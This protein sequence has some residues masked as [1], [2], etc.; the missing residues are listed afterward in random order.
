[1]APR[2]REREIGS[3]AHTRPWRK[4]VLWAR[5]VRSESTHFHGNRLHPRVWVSDRSASVSL[6]DLALVSG[7]D[8]DQRVQVAHAQ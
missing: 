7:F 5:T 6:A 3:S 1:M 2:S 4:C 8:L